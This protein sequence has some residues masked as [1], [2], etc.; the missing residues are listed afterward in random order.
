MPRQYEE[1]RGLAER[2]SCSH[3]T[4]SWPGK[5]TLEARVGLYSVVAAEAPQTGNPDTILAYCA[6]H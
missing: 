4:R 1:E 2:Y 3:V 6:V 5:I